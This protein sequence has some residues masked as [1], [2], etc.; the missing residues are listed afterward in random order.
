M[1][2][3]Y[4]WYQVAWDLSIDGGMDP[5]THISFKNQIAEEINRDIQIGKIKCWN[6]NGD[7]LRG[8]IPLAKQRISVPHLTTKETNEWLDRNG[9]LVQWAPSIEQKIPTTHT[10]KKTTDPTKS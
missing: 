6:A 5:D 10:G 3:L 7:P 1:E 2:N 9:Y 4:P 8:G